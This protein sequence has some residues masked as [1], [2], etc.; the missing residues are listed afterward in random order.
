MRYLILIIGLV[1]CIALSNAQNQTT[2]GTCGEELTNGATTLNFTLGQFANSSYTSSPVS[3]YEGFH[4]P[5]CAASGVITGCDFVCPGISGKTYTYKVD[6]AGFE[7][8]ISWSTSSP[9]AN[10][11]IYYGDSVEVQFPNASTINNE[12]KII[13]T[14]N[15]SCDGIPIEYTVDFDKEC[16]LPGDVNGDGIVS[17]TTD[18]NS[19]GLGFADYT[20]VFS[21]TDTFALRSVSCQFEQF[22]DLGYHPCID[23]P[24]PLITTTNYVNAKH[25]DCNSNGVLRSNPDIHNYNPSDPPVTD[26]DVIRHHSIVNNFSP[27]TNEF[28]NPNHQL[29]LIRMDSVLPGGNEIRLIA[30]LGNGTSTIDS[31]QGIAFVARFQIGTY[32]NPKFLASYSHM[33]GFD[34]IHY[35]N[36]PDIEGDTLNPVWH[37]YIGRTDRKGV[38]YSGEEVCRIECHA[39][40]AG[41]PPNNFGG[42]DSI[43]IGIKI[44]EAAYVTSNGDHYPLFGDSVTVYARTNFSYFR[45]KALLDG[46]LE[47][48]TGIMKDDLRSTYR[49]PLTEPYTQ[50]GAVHHGSGGEEISPIILGDKGNNS[51]V[52]WVFLEFRNQ[53]DP[54]LIENTSIGLIQ[55]DGDIVSLDGE[56]P[57]RLIGLYSDQYHVVLR[58]RNHLAIMTDDSY[59]FANEDT[60]VVDFMQVPLYGTNPVKVNAATSALWSGDADFSGVI[61]APDRNLTWND[62]NN[63][64]PKYLNTDCNMDGFVNASDRS[65]VWNHRNLQEQIP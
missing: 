41:S 56:S 37:I 57:L 27:I 40:I 61:S 51:I 9:D 38:S 15:N 4:Q 64:I 48:S 46:P 29:N 28:N 23:W 65:I 1:G 14:S 2:L 49:I 8:N 34:S 55:R 26:L 31:V 3:L 24:F 63:S 44:T 6:F 50:L 13:A 7:G 42:S 21:L 43:P 60:T 47:I 32:N 19:F 18:A 12:V 62:R 52:D 33:G 54:T 45:G 59:S 39:T 11:I 53:L 16:V 25:F 22:Y 10:I 58:H 35:A 17:W 36:Y 30:A 5:T 20:D